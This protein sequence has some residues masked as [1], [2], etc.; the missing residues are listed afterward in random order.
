MSKYSGI[1]AAGAIS[2]A[3]SA[4]SE[5]ENNNL[6]VLNDIGSSL[7]DQVASN[8]SMN[9]LTIKSEINAL[10]EYL[11]DVIGVAS[12]ILRYQE[13]EKEI[14]NLEAQKYITET[15]YESEIS[16]DGK[17]KSVPKQRQVINQNIANK[18]EELKREME[19]IEPSIV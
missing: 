4:L 5:P 7:S 10:N 2:A 6:Q 9:L 14:A 18:I 17:E 16:S 12:N 8:V 1:D 15:Y 3:E 13:L 11:N 19:S